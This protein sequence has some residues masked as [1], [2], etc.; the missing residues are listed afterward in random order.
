[1][2]ATVVTISDTAKDELGVAISHAV[3]TANL[4]QGAA[5][6]GTNLTSGQAF[7][8][9]TGTYTLAISATDDSGTANLTAEGE[10]LYEFTVVNPLSRE[11]YQQ[12]VSPVPHAV[13][14]VTLA[15][16]AALA[17]AFSE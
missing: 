12:F 7:A 6:S 11:K 4:V 8:S 1:M 13:T 3:I 10:V 15:T 9:T 5:N 16:L 17:V 14:T 2:S